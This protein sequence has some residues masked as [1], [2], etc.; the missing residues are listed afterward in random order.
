VA[1]TAMLDICYSVT[2]FLRVFVGPL[3][4]FRMQHCNPSQEED[5]RLRAGT[6]ARLVVANISGFSAGA[7]QGHG[8]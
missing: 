2:S 5:H 4:S 8:L 7:R 3:A 1:R 6:R